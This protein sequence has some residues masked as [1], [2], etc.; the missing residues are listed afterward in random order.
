MICDILY[1]RMGKA[2]YLTPTEMAKIWHV[3]PRRVRQLCAMGLVMGA[4]QLPNG[5][6]YL[7][8]GLHRPT[9]RRA[10][11]YRKVPNHLRF[12]IQRIDNFKKDRKLE[13]VDWDAFKIRSAFHLHTTG[14]SGITLRDVAELAEIGEA[15][16]SKPKKDQLSVL[17]HFAA[18]E[19]V[20]HAVREKR[21][22]TK[23][24][25]QDFYR[26]M[27]GKKRAMLPVDL[28]VELEAILSKARMK[29]AHPVIQAGDFLNEMFLTKPLT[30]ENVR[31]GY[32]MANFLL[33]RAGYPP[34]V[35]CRIIFPST[36]RH[37]ELM[38]KMK[39]TPV[40]RRAFINACVVNSVIHSYY[41]FVS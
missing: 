4:R 23:A 5:E 17:R 19:V 9:D 2:G 13:L 33:M 39:V 31:V 20:R 7:I 8:K 40:K 11:R 38:A 34:I 25:L 3:T 6:W 14:K 24:L 18:L 12:K 21:R 28:P 36:I 30:E 29:D 41:K 16:L 15:T 27:V 37:W 35:I 1:F 10:Y 22:L 26:A 32:M